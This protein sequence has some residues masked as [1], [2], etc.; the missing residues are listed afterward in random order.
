MTD[1]AGPPTCYRSGTPRV[2]NWTLHSCHSLQVVADIRRYWAPTLSNA[3]HTSSFGSS[4]LHISIKTQF[5][6]RETK[7]NRGETNLQSDQSLANGPKRPPHLYG[8]APH[9]NIFTVLSKFP[10]TPAFVALVYPF[11]L[12]SANKETHSQ[13]KPIPSIL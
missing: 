10:D 5:I 9:H 12:H 1:S 8:M 13:G 2:H 6:L 7:E 11:V 3:C 4:P